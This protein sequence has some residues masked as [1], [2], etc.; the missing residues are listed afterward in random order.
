MAMN[1]KSTIKKRIK[2]TDEERILN[3]TDEEVIFKEVF[4]VFNKDIVYYVSNLQIGNKPTLMA[5]TMI[6]Q[7]FGY[8][9]RDAKEQLETGAKE[10]ILYEK[11]NEDELIPIYKI[12]VID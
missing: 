8:D 4:D 10:V 11:N 5:G 2:S 7:F 12:E 1:K 3:N 9:N 6:E